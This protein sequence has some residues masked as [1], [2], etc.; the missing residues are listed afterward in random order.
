M[1]SAA[2]EL[3]YRIKLDVYYDELVKKIDV[4]VEN[5]FERSNSEFIKSSLIKQRDEAVIALEQ[6][7]TR[8]L[9]RLDELYNK[10]NHEL[11]SEHELF[12][13]S[14]LLLTLDQRVFQL[15]IIRVVDKWL[16]KE[17]VDLFQLIFLNDRLLV[18]K[19]LPGFEVIDEDATQAL[20]NKLCLNYVKIRIS[21]IILKITNSQTLLEI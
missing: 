19:R 20:M 7:K 4:F 6:D 1:N 5:C 17:Q 9:Q 10:R 21:S 13:N 15:G 18:T 14:T 8:S 2:S 11:I 3:D 12:N 16:S